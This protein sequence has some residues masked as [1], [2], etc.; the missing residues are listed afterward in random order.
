[1]LV[2][3][4]IGVSVIGVSINVIGGCCCAIG[5]GVSVIPCGGG[6]NVDGDGLSCQN[7]SGLKSALEQHLS[8][9][10]VLPYL[11]EWLSL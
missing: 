6:G 4:A 9:K 5:I 2:V 10:V 8:P 1:M 11:H 3:S 7:Q